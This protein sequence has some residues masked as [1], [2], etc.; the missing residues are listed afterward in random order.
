MAKFILKLFVFLLPFIAAV[1]VELFILPIDCFTFRLWE[2]LK[3]SAL[4]R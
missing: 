2:A 4:K 3:P 1:F